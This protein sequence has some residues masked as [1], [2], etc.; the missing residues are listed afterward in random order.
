MNIRK[1]ITAL[2]L[3]SGIAAAGLIS[4]A[5]TASAATCYEGRVVFN[6]DAGDYYLPDSPTFY[7]TTN[8]CADINISTNMSRDIKV[9]FYKS[10]Y[11]LNYCQANYTTT[12]ASQYT[13]IASD[14][15][16]GVLFRF[17]FRTSGYSQGY[18][19]R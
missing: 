11:S 18:V 7:K 2:V 17:R 1:K 9:C 12:T 15:N 5:P 10:D 6:K 3:A 4:A 13:V 16:D 8:R 19:A 14:V